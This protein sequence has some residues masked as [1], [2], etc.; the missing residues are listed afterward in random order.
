MAISKKRHRG[1]SAFDPE[2]N[3][4]LSKVYDDINEIVESVN[5]SDTTEEKKGNEGKSGDIRIVKDPK[6][7]T[8]YYLE[9]RT[10]EGWIQST[11]TTDSGFEFRKK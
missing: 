5:Q 2:L 9:A 3:R 7:A 1:S 8:K 11:N 10:E 4:A 6:D